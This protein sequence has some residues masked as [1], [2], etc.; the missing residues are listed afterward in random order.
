MNL[1]LAEADLSRPVQKPHALW[2]W[3]GCNP[4]PVDGRHYRFFN[5]HPQPTF[6]TIAIVSVRQCIFSAFLREIAYHQSFA[7]IYVVVQP[8]GYKCID[9]HV[10]WC[11]S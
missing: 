1:H 7:G 3:P 6:D 2:L 10:L 8:F 9:C 5:R 4:Q 11:W